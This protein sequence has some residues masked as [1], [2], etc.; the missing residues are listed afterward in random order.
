MSTSSAPLVQPTPEEKLA[1]SLNFMR[2]RMKLTKEFIQSVSSRLAF[3]GTCRTSKVPCNA[4]YDPDFSVSV[5]EWRD[6]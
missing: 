6:V 2:I 4:G 1:N 3:S 5:A